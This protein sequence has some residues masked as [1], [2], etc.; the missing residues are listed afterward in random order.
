[1]LQCKL[2]GKGGIWFNYDKKYLKLLKNEESFMIKDEEISNK[3]QKC[4]IIN[5]TWY[6]VDKNNNV[7]HTATTPTI[8]KGH[9]SK[10]LTG[11]NEK[12]LTYTK[13]EIIKK[14]STYNERRALNDAVNNCKL[15]YEKAWNLISTKFSIPYS[16][17]RNEYLQKEGL[18]VD[19]L[20]FLYIILSK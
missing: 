2:K 6:V 12:R 20:K 1:M 15:G 8:N 11:K 10:L 13:K 3:Q 18:C 5:N 9:T 17:N 19:A 7:V 16:V 14:Q 4:Y